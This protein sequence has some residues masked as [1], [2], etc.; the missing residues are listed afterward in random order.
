MSTAIPL[1][2]LV[3]YSFLDLAGSKKLAVKRVLANSALVTIGV[4]PGVLQRIFVLECWR[5]REK[6]NQLID[7]VMATNE[8][9]H[10]IQFGIEANAMQSLFAD[11]VAHEAQRLQQRLPLI[12][13]NQPTKI[14][15]EWRIRDALQPVIGHGRLFIL[16][17][18]IELTGEVTGFPLAALRDMIDALASAVALVPLKA[19]APTKA[20]VR[21]GLARYLRQI[22][23]P[24]SVIEARLVAYDKAHSDVAAP[25]R[26]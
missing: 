24:A 21:E 1:D 2:S 6:A 5:G 25:S 22:G 26:A 17:S 8:R 4:E 20:A 7:R 13:V 23:T 3:K 14:D 12:P 9:W 16:P 15:K 18:M 11:L 19:A 10:P